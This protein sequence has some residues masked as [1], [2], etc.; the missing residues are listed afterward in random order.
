MTIGSFACFCIK[1]DGLPF[2]VAKREGIIVKKP[3][4]YTE[5]AYVLGVLLL[6]LATALMEQGAFGMSIVVAPAYVVHLKLSEIWP[7]VTF[8]MAEYVLQTLIL[9]VTLLIVGRVRL[10]WLLAF[11]TTALYSL[12]LDGFL[13]ITAL[14]PTLFAVRVAIYALGFCLC[15]TAV[16]LILHGYL[17]PSAYDLYAKLVTIKTGRPLSV[18][19]TT[20]DLV[21][22]A[23]AVGLSLWFFGGIRGVGVG[24]VAG[25]LL[26]GVCIRKVMEW[27]GGL[28]DFRDLLPWRRHFE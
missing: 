12:A 13:L 5:I 2:Y 28:F 24:T 23:V 8:G 1:H 4:F 20:Y 21:S 16:G 27:L 19:K 6:A 9:S 3:V 15:V 22:L 25:A 11:G 14:I 7:W 26:G 17:P 10:T 18:V